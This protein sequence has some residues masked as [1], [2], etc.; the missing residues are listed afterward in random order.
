[1]QTVDHI[2]DS[3]AGRTSSAPPAGSSDI[4]PLETRDISAVA[5]LYQKILLNLPEPA[6]A[7]LAAH[8]E[9]VFLN[10]PWQDPEIPSRVFVDDAGQVGGFIGVLPA[11]M[12]F[13]DQQV[14]TAVAGSLMVADPA[15]NPLAGAR[16]L[17]AVR[18]G[19]QDLCVSETANDVSMGMWEQMGDQALSQY[20]MQWVRVFKPARFAAAALAEKRRAA[21]VL[22]PFALLADLAVG[23][24]L[25]GAQDADDKPAKYRVQA[26]QGEDLIAAIRELSAEFA[27]RPDWDDATLEWLLGHADQKARHGE[28]RC[29]VVLGRNGKLLGCHIYFGRPGG[30]AWVL[31]VLSRPKSSSEVVSSLL[32]HARNSGCVAIRG[33]TQPDTVTPLMRQGAFFFCN[34]AAVIHTRDKALREAVEQ[35]NALI[36]GLAGESWVRLIGDRFE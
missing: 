31:Q 26:V 35:G 7:S 33:R 9:D 29:H 23:R 1:M 18:G 4:R 32:D 14:R 30:V 11:R 5:G 25:G 15:S 13:G 34:S 22:K 20:S 27:L 3:T 28:M 16:L 8:L 10:H 17:R 6:P 19:V 2:A 36:T 12:V 21:A 24:F